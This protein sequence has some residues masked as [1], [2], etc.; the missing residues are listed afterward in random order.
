[1]GV[2]K[3]EEALKVFYYL[4]SV[5]GEISSEELTFFDE[6][7]QELLGEEYQGKKQSLIDDCNNQIHNNIDDSDVAYDLISEGVDKALRDTIGNP[8]QG[9]SP[10]LLVWN[11]LV[12]A[13]SNDE[14]SKT[15]R[16]LIKHIV[17]THSIDSS[18]FLEME[19]MIQTLNAVSNELRWLE[20]SNRPYAEIR[21][22]VEENEKRQAVIRESARALIEDEVIP[23]EEENE[24]HLKAYWQEQKAKIEDRV[25][26]VASEVA[27]QTEKLMGNVKEQSKNLFG[28]A[29][30]LFVKKEKEE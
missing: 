3:K 24:D 13:L 11:L 10:R 25:N 16:R 12:M 19:Q 17:R 29:K 21:P 22:L 2:F 18:V 15:E 1:M 6:V 30:K 27:A 9:V 4:M 28:N 23:L 20:D 14:Y 26:P 7:G 5:D 8:S